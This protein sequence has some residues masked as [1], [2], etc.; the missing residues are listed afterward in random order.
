MGELLP[1]PECFACW[2][3]DLSFFPIS[4]KADFDSPGVC[5]V[6]SWGKGALDAHLPWG[7]VLPLPLGYR[8]GLWLAGMP[9]PNHMLE[10]NMQLVYPK[11]RLLPIAVCFKSYTPLFRL[12]ELI[13]GT[14]K[15]L[16]YKP[17]TLL[18]V[19][20]SGLFPRFWRREGDLNFE[21]MPSGLASDRKQR[22]MFFGNIQ[23]MNPSC[24]M[25]A[26]RW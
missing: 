13:A 7:G 24:G 10:D 9:V 26:L 11:A 4:H 1:I 25:A 15:T 19:L 16:G 23:R 18:L 22:R 5:A 17:R 14:G 8:E 2:T 12:H 21:G 6:P 3:A 20:V